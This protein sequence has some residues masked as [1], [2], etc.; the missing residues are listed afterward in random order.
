MTGK[1]K[2]YR[3]QKKERKV[4]NKESDRLG[5]KKNHKNKNPLSPFFFLLPVLSAPVGCSRQIRFRLLT[6]NKS[7]C[8][9]TWTFRASISLSW[10]CSIVLTSVIPGRSAVSRTTAENSPT[11]VS[12][13]DSALKLD[14]KWITEDVNSL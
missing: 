1:N 14:A 2:G 7:N 12:L 13:R 9:F 6:S 10:W 8:N 4:D 11:S 5:R 3:S